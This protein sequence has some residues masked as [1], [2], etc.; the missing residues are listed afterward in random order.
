MRLAGPSRNFLRLCLTFV[1]LMAMVLLLGAVLPMA[2]QD[3]AGAY[4]ESSVKATPAEQAASKQYAKKVPSSTCTEGQLPLGDGGDLQVTTGTCHVKAGIYKYRNVNIYKGGELLFDDTGNTDFWAQSI[5]VE[6]DGSLVA[7]SAQV[8]Y[9]VNGTLTIHL[10]GAAQSTGRGQGVAAP[11]KYD[12]HCGIPD[13]LWTSN[14]MAISRMFPS[15]FRWAIF[16]ISPRPAV[17]TSPLSYVRDGRRQGLG[18]PGPLT[19][20]RSSR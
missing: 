11:C 2:A 19:R 7:G 20:L 3:D 6:R 18:C 5:I 8:P 9:G 14:V 13:P 1:C 12:D 16:S 10:W 4:Q 17:P 15:Y